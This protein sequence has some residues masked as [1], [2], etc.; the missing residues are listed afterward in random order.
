MLTTVYE[1][2][3]GGKRYIIADAKS[4]DTKPT[5]DILNGS[6]INDIDTGKIYKFDQDSQTWKEQ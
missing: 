4:T 3:I 2:W 1:K 5:G 6:V